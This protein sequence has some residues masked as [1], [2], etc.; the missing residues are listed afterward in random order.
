L[1]AGAAL[2]RPILCPHRDEGY[3]F[4]LQAIAA[5]GITIH[6]FCTVAK[7]FSVPILVLLVI[8]ALGPGKW[9]PRTHLGWQFDHFIGYFGITL[10]FCF[11]WPRP[12]MLGG[13][14]AA[15]AALLECL[16]AFTPDRSAYLP[17]VFYGAA[18]ALAAALVAELFIRVWRTPAG[19]G[20][21]AI[22]RWFETSSRFL[23]TP[24]PHAIA[25]AARARLR[26]TEGPSSAFPVAIGAILGSVVLWP[27]KRGR[28]EPW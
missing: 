21:H 16:Q 11:A 18:G 26:P 13:I 4:K 8:A 7:A 24:A 6:R 28:Q 19:V 5:S 20:R 2:E 22:I 9:A 17:A 1:D 12:F 15:V 23:A 27:P 3:Y 14:F 25:A 10:F